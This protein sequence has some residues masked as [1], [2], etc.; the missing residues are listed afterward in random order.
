MDLTPTLLIRVPLPQG[1]VEI[2]EWHWPD[3]IDFTRTESE[4]MLEMSLPPL[5]TDASAEFPGL[6][7][8]NFCFV[9]TLF[10]RFP[11]VTVHGRGEGGHIRVLRFIFGPELARAVLGD[12]GVPAVPVLQ[13]LLDI[14]S[15]SLRKMMALALREMTTR[16]DRSTQALGAIQTLLAV[17]L[18]RIV[19]RR[20]HATPGGRLAAWQYR[21]VR[22]RLAQGGTT[23]SA[24][25]LAALCGIS[26]RHLNRQ[27]QALTGSSV[28][29]YIANFLIERAKTMLERDDMPIKSVA[30]ALGFAHANSFARAFRR[31]TGLSP[32]RFRQRMAATRQAAA[33]ATSP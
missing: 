9:G 10:T 15:E 33:P 1:H 4:L 22:E 24:S 17:E 25:E 8:G 14:R 29:D 11:G 28:A 31:A 18:R 23:P 7:P 27:F 16:E 2:V 3:I 20:L 5:A 12:E 13:G 26:V 21:K 19:E 6:D 30:H 32:Q